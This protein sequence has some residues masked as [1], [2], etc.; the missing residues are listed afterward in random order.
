[1]K[2]N[3]T[4]YKNIDS[5]RF[6]IEAALDPSYTIDSADNKHY[7]LLI[8]P[9]HL[10]KNDVYDILAISVEGTNN[11]KIA[12]ALPYF[13][14]AYDILLLSDNLLTLLI[15]NC[16]VQI[17][18]DTWSVKTEALNIFGMTF[19]IYSLGDRY[20][21]HG[22]LEIICLNDQLE[23]L[24]SFSGNDAFVSVSGK[25]SFEITENSIRLNDFEDAFYELDFDG[26]IISEN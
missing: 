8:N 14:F 5:G 24:W 19:S 16:V 4:F 23:V 26:N 11:M 20:V 21:I 10:A 25:A 22:E 6:F 13:N 12:V 1:M 2:D 3:N 15:D 17:D 7:D 18:L 9:C